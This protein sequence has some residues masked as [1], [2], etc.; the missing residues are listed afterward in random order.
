MKRLTSIIIA[1]VVSLTAWFSTANLK[2]ETV[3]A[4]TSAPIEKHLILNADGSYGGSYNESL[5]GKGAPKNGELDVLNSPYYIAQDFYNIKSTSEAYPLTLLPNFKP[6]QQTMANSSAF[7][8]LVMALNYY[9]FDVTG[10]L[11]EVELYKSYEAFK[12][13]NSIDSSDYH[14]VYLSSFISSL[15]LTGVKVERQPF[16]TANDKKTAQSLS[17]FI[18]NELSQGAIYMVRYH[19]QVDF[20]WKLIIGIDQMGT[21]V[22][23]DDTLILANPYDVSDHYQDGYSTQRLGSFVTWFVEIAENNAEINMDEGIL[24]TFDNPKQIER[25]ARDTSVKQQAYDTHFILN[26]EDS[27]FRYGGTRNEALYGSIST[28]DGMYNSVTTEYY[29][30]NDYY[31]MGDEG[32]RLLIKNY[33][34]FQQTMASSCGIASIMSV[35]S[36]LG[37]DITEYDEVTLCDRYEALTGTGIVKKGTT[38]NGLLKTVEERGF[39]GVASSTS[40]TGEKE[41]PT[42]ESY[43]DFIK[44]HLQNDQPIA[45]AARPQ[46]G[47]WIVII[48][49]DDMGTDNI[50]DDIIITADPNDYWDHYQDGYNTYSATHLYRTH[51]AGNFGSSHSYLIIK[52]PQSIST[53]ALVLIV[54][55]AV[56]VLAGITFAVIYFIKKFKKIKN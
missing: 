8:C 2:A 11:S 34:T 56:I 24:L 23:Y 18:S 36:Y 26:S 47:H 31:N 6:Y 49:I 45:I 53:L 48:G 16:N 15:N 5:Y 27:E 44:G 28:G 9:N 46:G 33:K 12:T 52:K 37:E 39:V 13:A 41:F 21:E 25:I 50:Y 14:S 22:Y 19:S 30:I 3:K 40:K 4:S 51:Y 17:K 55:G 42:Y 29:K 1:L 7:A 32:S 10:S 54:V 35:L 38:G 43:R 20:G